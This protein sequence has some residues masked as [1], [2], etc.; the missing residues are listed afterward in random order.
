MFQIVWILK[1]SSFTLALGLNISPNL[2][3][4]HPSNTLSMKS[5]DI[6]G[7][8][9]GDI[10]N[11]GFKTLPRE[12]F[13][14]HNDGVWTKTIPDFPFQPRN[15]YS[16][17]DMIQKGINPASRDIDSCKNTTGKFGK[18]VKLSKD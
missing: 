7:G 17:Y 1:Y 11:G 13:E 10:Q 9:G 4:E 2:T 14:S 15:I 18:S 12:W 16:Y 8:N 6:T 3:N 5:R